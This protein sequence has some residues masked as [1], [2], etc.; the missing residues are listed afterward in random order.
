MDKTQPHLHTYLAYKSWTRKKIGPP[1]RSLFFPN[2]IA[3][4]FVRIYI[5]LL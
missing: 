2:V 1:A 3:K 4:K 5:K